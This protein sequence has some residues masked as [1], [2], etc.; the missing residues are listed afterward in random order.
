M[1]YAQRSFQEA[2]PY[3]LFFQLEV[4]LFLFIYI[5]LQWTNLFINY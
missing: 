5:F 1:F 4:L 2:P 3:A